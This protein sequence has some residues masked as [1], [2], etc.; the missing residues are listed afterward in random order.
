MPTSQ[1]VSPELFYIQ[2]T[3][4]A[5]VAAVIASIVM[6][7]FQICSS[8]KSLKVQISLQLGDR[9]DE[10]HM[11]ENRRD[12]ANL[13]LTNVKPT[14]AQME[15]VLDHLETVADFYLRGWV[16]KGIIHN[17]FCIPFRYWW[18]ALSSDVNTLRSSFHDVTLYERTEKLANIYN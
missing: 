1:T 7:L 8:K 17:S 6:V 10:K 5:A 15:V 13:L 16:D 4:W 18:A 9:Y 12:L 2:I 11:R 14:S 3:A